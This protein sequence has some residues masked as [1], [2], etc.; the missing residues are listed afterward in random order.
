MLP[1]RRKGRRRWRMTGELGHQMIDQ[2][3][4]LTAS[5][6]ET[7]CG[8]VNKI[9]NVPGATLQPL[10]RQVAGKGFLSEHSC[11][12]QPLYTY[13]RSLHSFERDIFPHCPWRTPSLIF[14]DS[15]QFQQ[16][17]NAAPSRVRRGCARSAL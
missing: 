1:W 8:D 4:A 3:L 11:P 10:F 2:A 9:T 13:W 12:P 15:I 17:K 14:P 16:K 7:S 5:P 6:D